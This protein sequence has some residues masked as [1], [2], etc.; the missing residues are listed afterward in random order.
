[1]TKILDLTGAPVLG[2][3]LRINSKHKLRSADEEIEVPWPENATFDVLDAAAL[4]TADHL[5]CMDP[6]FVVTDKLKEVLAAQCPEAKFHAATANGKRVWIVAGPDGDVTYESQGDHADYTRNGY[7]VTGAKGLHVKE[8]PEH[9]WADVRNTP[10]IAL[11][12]DLVKAAAKAGVRWNAVDKIAEYRPLR[13]HPYTILRCHP[14]VAVDDIEAAERMPAAPAKVPHPRR[15]FTF[16]LALEPS[17]ILMKD[18]DGAWTELVHMDDRLD[19]CVRPR[20]CS[21]LPLPR[22]RGTFKPKGVKTRWKKI[23]KSDAIACDGLPVVSTKIKEL[24]GPTCRYTP[25]DL[26]DPTASKK[27]VQEGFWI[28][29][30]PTVAWIDWERSDVGYLWDGQYE[31]FYGLHPIE[32]SYTATDPVVRIEGTPL[33]LVHE[34][35]AAQLD[36]PFYLMP[37]HERTYALNNDDCARPR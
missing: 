12:A 23:L 35:I 15:G 21:G 22:L 13:P 19:R 33:V 31:S 36:D 34:S 25:F 37:L 16:D 20:Y 17:D 4:D 26:I 5:P 11:H 7:Q 8:K 10:V 27:K 32:S 3:L 24:F 28:V 29:E 14:A 2:R 6:L 9:A 1:M 30:P 18:A